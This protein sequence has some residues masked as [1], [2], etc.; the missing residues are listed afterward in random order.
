MSFSSRW[1]NPVPTLPVPWG[2]AYVKPPANPGFLLPKI[3]RTSTSGASGLNFTLVGPP[4]GVL[5]F[6]PTSPSSVMGWRPLWIWANSLALAA[7][8]IA[9]LGDFHPVARS[10]RWSISSCWPKVA[11]RVS[12]PLNRSTAKGKNLSSPWVFCFSRAS[13][14]LRVLR[15]ELVVVWPWLRPPLT[16][17][18][19][20]RPTV[21]SSPWSRPQRS[22]TRWGTLWVYSICRLV[23]FDTLGLNSRAGPPTDRWNAPNAR[24]PSSFTARASNAFGAL[25]ISWGLAVLYLGFSSPMGLG[26]LRN[27]SQLGPS[28]FT[29]VYSSGSPSWVTNRIWSGRE[30]KTSASPWRNSWTVPAP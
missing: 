15:I 29:M 23:R 9:T 16:A 20:P 26:S 24:A 30:Y 12:W 21:S 13:R 19:S 7:G 11:P 1:V 22:L 27:S 28:V 14:A 5:R 4:P 18:S 8:L 10:T 2:P 25:V 6:H 3:D 17:N